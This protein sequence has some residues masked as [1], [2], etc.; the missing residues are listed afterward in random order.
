V[1]SRPERR[2]AEALDRRGLRVPAQILVDAH[3]PLAPLLGDI[4]SALG[5]LARLVGGR[6]AGELAALVEDPAG[7]E[8]LT[9]E[10][11]GA[12]ADAR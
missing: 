2:L 8:R 12:R 9:G 11:E 5:P 10:L 3:R 6:P 1:S 4:A 7:L